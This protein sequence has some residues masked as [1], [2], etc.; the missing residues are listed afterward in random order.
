MRTTTM[1]VLAALMMPGIAVAQTAG[2]RPAAPATPPSA[3]TPTPAAPAAGQYTSEADAKGHC[4]SDMVVWMN[5]ASHVY[6]YAGAR[7]YGHTKS[8]GYM[9]KADA[10]K[11][12]RAAKNEKPPK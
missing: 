2:S 8:G 1:A 4:A 11:A 5:N 3:A 7:D 10:D 12:G 6:H 9:C